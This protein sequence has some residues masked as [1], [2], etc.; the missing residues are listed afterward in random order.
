MSSDPRCHRCRQVVVIAR[1]VPGLQQIR[2]NPEPTPAGVYE[3]D[4]DALPTPTAR[5][6]FWGD[7]PPAV[8]AHQNGER[9]LYTPHVET[10]RHRTGDPTT[11]RSGPAA[12]P[13]VAASGP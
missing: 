1:T 4:L 9:R 13:S 11:D 8:V 12:A 7:V 3:L 5:R 6:L 2:L 10:C